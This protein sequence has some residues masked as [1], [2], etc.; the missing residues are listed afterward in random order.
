MASSSMCWGWHLGS[1]QKRIGLGIGIHGTGIWAYSDIS[2]FH[3][4]IRIYSVLDVNVIACWLC[5][6]LYLLCRCRGTWYGVYSAVI[7]TGSCAA[8]QIRCVLGIAPRSPSTHTPHQTHNPAAQKPRRR[9]TSP[10]LYGPLRIPAAATT[11][12]TPRWSTSRRTR[13][14]RRRSCRRWSR[15]CWTSTSGWRRT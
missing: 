10:S 2:S 1:T 7:G 3:P 5:F 11:T 15:R 13:S 14:S 12:G 9:D 4:T 8:A 6:V